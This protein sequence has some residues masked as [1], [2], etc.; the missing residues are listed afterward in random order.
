MKVPI[1]TAK[2]ASVRFAAGASA[3]PGSPNWLPRGS[4]LFQAMGP[5]GTRRLPSTVAG[6]VGGTL[7]GIP[8]GAADGA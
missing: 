8:R 5:G 4:E 7:D 3:E 2:Q 1:A 6:T